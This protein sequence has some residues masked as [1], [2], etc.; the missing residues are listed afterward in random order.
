MTR[1]RPPLPTNVYQLQ[2]ER[3]PAL[4][5][6]EI[7]FITSTKLHEEHE[8]PTR[9]ESGVFG[10]D[11]DYLWDYLDGTYQFQYRGAMVQKRFFVPIQMN[12]DKRTLHVLEVR[13]DFGKWK[14]M[15]STLWS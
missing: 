13:E 14:P 1:T 11:P 7:G 2:I 4:Q 6:V 3:V 15:K 5:N 9:I 12:F 8:I 10:D